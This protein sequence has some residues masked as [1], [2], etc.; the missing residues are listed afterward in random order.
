MALKKILS[1]RNR[2]NKMRHSLHKAIGK[3]FDDGFL[4]S[5]CEIFKDHA[6]G[7]IQNLPLFVSE[8]KS[9]PT[10]Y[11]N[12]DLLIIKADKIKVI[13]E[14]EESDVKPTQ[15]CGKFLTSALSFCYIGGY[16]DFKRI[17]M[18]DDVLF[19]QILDTSKL[20]VD[21]TKKIEQWKNIE[22]SIKN[23]IPLKGSQIKEYKLFYGRIQD[24]TGEVE[25]KKE[26]IDYI[27]NFLR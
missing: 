16:K 27:R 9:F 20:K 23:I 19:I 8:E 13:F 5:G 15:I 26:F 14:I 4:P 1:M 3:I 18:D 12:I 10:E 25:K 11:C 2:I 17:R 24:F 6:C 7:G 22:N 21:K